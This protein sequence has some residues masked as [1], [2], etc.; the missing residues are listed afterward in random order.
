MYANRRYISALQEVGVGNTTVTS[1]L[2][3][4][5]NMAVSLMHSE[6][7]TQYNPYLW[8]NRCFLQAIEVDEHDSDV[9]FYTGLG[10]VANIPRSTERMASFAYDALHNT[11]AQSQNSNVRNAAYKC[12]C[13]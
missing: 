11:T 6:K 10:Y 9:R 3:R 12:Q 8:P 5:G 2:D 7:N 13:D 4:S 1:D